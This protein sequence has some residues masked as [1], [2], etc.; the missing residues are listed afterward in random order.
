LGQTNFVI[1]AVSSDIDQP[2]S[3]SNIQ[4][5]DIPSTIYIPTAFSP[6][7]DGTNDVLKFTGK[8]KTKDK[9]VLKIYN[10]FGQQIK[11][12]NNFSETWDGR[13]DGKDLESG[14]YLYSYS[15]IPENG[16]RMH[17]SG[18]ITILR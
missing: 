12:I 15:V 2:A 14:Q 4:S 7:G 17:K 1:K 5:L 18:E 9:F 13:F 16:P 10:R 3:T 11:Q 8:F 6:N